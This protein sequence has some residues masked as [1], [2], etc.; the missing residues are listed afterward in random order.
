MIPLEY[1]FQVD[2]TTTSLLLFPGQGSQF[3]GM[4][5]NTLEYSEA[6]DLYD[7]ASDIVQY[8]ILKVCLDGPIELLSRTEV[9]QTATLVTSLAALVKLREENPEVNG[10]FISLDQIL[11]QFLLS[12]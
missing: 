12:H 8:D 3:V 2:P 1:L 9:C 5:K 10:S 7:I 4:G 11:M 6:K